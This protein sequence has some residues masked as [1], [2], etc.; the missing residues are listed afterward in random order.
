[1]IYTGLLKCKPD[2]RDYLME[3]FL[4]D[5]GLPSHFDLTDE[6]PTIKSQ[7]AEGSC[8]GFSGSYL[9]E[10]QEQIE[11]G[12]FIELSPRFLYEKAKELYWG[13]RAQKKEGADLRSVMKV[14]LDLGI[15]EEHLW[16]YVA[17]KRG[18]PDEF[19]YDN[20]GKYRIKNYARIRT[21]RELRAS[22][23]QFGVIIAGILLY[24]SVRKTGKDGIIPNPNM[25]WPSNWRPIGGHAI[26]ICGYND[27]T[28][29]VKFV[30][31]W[32]K[33]WGQQGFGYVSYDYIRNHLMDAYSC[34]DITLVTKRHIRVVMDLDVISRN[35]VWKVGLE[36]EWA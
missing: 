16:P 28:K 9:K 26:A 2:D 14:L 21:L 32:G 11:W 20:A 15:C 1:M 8:T 4:D 36:R 34:V 33:K 29:L 27:N 17:Q 12:M 31:S 5:R 22:L 10:Y 18:E 7:G 19:A 25:A 24:K 35:N 13:K 6:I 23:V 30:N 3:A